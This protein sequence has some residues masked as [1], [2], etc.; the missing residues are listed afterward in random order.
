ME[1]D[2]WRLNL[3]EIRQ[4]WNVFNG[5]RVL[6]VV[7][8]DGLH[9][10]AS[11]MRELGK[12]DCEWMWLPNDRDLREVVTF[13][14]LL[15]SIASTSRREASFYAHTK[16]TS[17]ELGISGPR[18]WRNTMYRVL[19]DNIEVV[20]A[21]LLTHV[22]VG[23]TK[24]VWPDGATPPYPN[25]LRHGNWMFAGT[26]FWFKHSEVFTR[27]DWRV[28]PQDRYGAE[29]WLSGMFHS[30]QALSLFQ[31]WPVEQYPTPSPY[32]PTLYPHRRV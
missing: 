23:T 19:L 9:D 8:G 4:R 13:L 26:Y 20:R 15:E 5:R 10:P 7:K 16:G 22:A 21:A 3:A 28:I 30:D 18:A 14:P 17:S 12:D 27:D 6:A 29:S 31:P 32:D 2:E 11:V 1:N 25:R 24:M